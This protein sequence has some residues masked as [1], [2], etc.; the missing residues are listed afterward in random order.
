MFGTLAFIATGCVIALAV[1]WLYIQSRQQRATALRAAAPRHAWSALSCAQEV[2][3]CPADHQLA[4]AAI[5]AR[6]RR[7]EARAGVR[8]GMAGVRLATAS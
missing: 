5:I 3:G 4:P 7:E 8:Y 2:C 1:A 6:L